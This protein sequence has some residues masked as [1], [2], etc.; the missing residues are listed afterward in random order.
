MHY[1]RLSSVWEEEIRKPG[2]S[3]W[4][5]LL[6]FSLK[7]VLVTI[8]FS[9][10]VVLLFRFFAP[11]VSALMVH[12]RIESWGRKSPYS[13][14][15]RWVRFEQ[16]TPIMGVAVIATE[17]QNFLRHHG[18]DWGAIEKAIDYNERSSRIRGASTIT[19]QTAKN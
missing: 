18:F 13:P 16:I 14:S 12:R 19:Q 10:A 7:C 15:Y 6:K 2:Q 3:W 5:R 11:P 9:V 1:L 4:R 8:L 17:D